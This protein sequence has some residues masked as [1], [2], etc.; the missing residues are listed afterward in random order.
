MTLFIHLFILHYE[1][2]RLPL[3][4]VRNILIIDKNEHILMQLLITYELKM[5]V[6]RE[7]A[8]N[9]SISTADKY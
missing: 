2:L 7:F 8:F 1:N 5:R 9:T 4:R 6:R 3:K